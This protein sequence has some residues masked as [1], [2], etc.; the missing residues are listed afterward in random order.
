MSSMFYF[1]YSMGLFVGFMC[2]ILFPTGPTFP[3]QSQTSTKNTIYYETSQPF[4]TY[5][6]ISIILLGDSNEKSTHTVHAVI[7]LSKPNIENYNLTVR[8]LEVIQSLFLT[9]RGIFSHKRG[10]FPIRFRYFLI[11][12]RIFPIKVKF[13]LINFGFFLIFNVFCSN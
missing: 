11:R 1:P 3:P 4:R 6:T 10:F 7:S 9:Q 2:Q 8:N 13:F 5:L 12:V